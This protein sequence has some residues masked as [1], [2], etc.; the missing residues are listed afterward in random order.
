V[1]VTQPN[2]QDDGVYIDFSR[3]QWRNFRSAES[4]CLSE[5]DLIDLRGINE[6]VSIA[7]VEDIY[8][9]LVRLLCVSMEQALSYQQSI[10]KFMIKPMQRVPYIVGVAGSVAV[11]K[12]TSSRLLQALL[13][14]QTGLRVDL[15]STDGFLLSRQDLSAQNLLQRKGF[16]ESY[17][18]DKLLFFLLSLKSGVVSHEVP[19]Y[20][21]INYDILPDEVQLI[22]HPE[23]VII[24]GLNILQTGPVGGK[25]VPAFV[26]DFLDFS[27]FIHA[28]E[29]DLKKWFI[30]RVLKFC[31]GPLLDSKAY[32]HFL[33][34]L[35]KAEIIDFAEQTWNDINGL[36]LR[37]NILPFKGRADLILNKTAD[38]SVGS[39]SL[40][41]F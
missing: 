21:H 36:N 39:V 20:S 19:L 17:H 6:P 31:A 29:V 5:T 25:S 15:V 1:Q 16:P 32:F 12:S 30:D 28:D 2:G 26:S 8:L 3:L 27:I 14:K 34:Q 38:H 33:T 40:R 10:S 22:E 18:L 35:N 4:V 41:K 23:I 24:E 11:G 9:P 37:E 7:D 13:R